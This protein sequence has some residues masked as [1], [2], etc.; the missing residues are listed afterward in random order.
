[1][2]LRRRTRLAL[3]AVLAV[4]ACALTGSAGI[5][6]GSPAAAGR[7][8][9]VA[10]TGSPQT[11][12]FTPSDGA[13]D[14]EFADEGDSEGGPGPYAGNIVDRSMSSG[15]AALGVATTTGKKAKSDPQF[16]FGFEGLNHYQQRYTRGGNQ[17][18]VDPPDQGMCGGNGYVSEACHRVTDA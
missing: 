11:G 15:G 9:P 16:N 8:I 7:L 1:M 12:A 6:V 4:A 3:G 14:E 17:F 10:G 5:A 13:V 2:T 18:S